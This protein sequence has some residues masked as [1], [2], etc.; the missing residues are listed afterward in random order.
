MRRVQSQIQLAAS[1][2][3]HGADA[4][5]RGKYRSATISLLSAIVS[6]PEF[7]PAFFNLGNCWAKLGQY[8]TAIWAYEQAVRYCDEYAPLF[9]NLGIVYCHSGQHDKALPYLQHAWRL[10]EEEIDALALGYA[11]TMLEQCEVAD[12]WY[13]TASFMDETKV[14]KRF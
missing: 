13:E 1:Y 11:Y 3:R 9:Y 14:R 10:R 2:N 8:E 12:D 6:D 4:M 5:S 7:W